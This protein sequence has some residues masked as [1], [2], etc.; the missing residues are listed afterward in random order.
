MGDFF[1]V[2]D[3]PVRLRPGVTPKPPPPPPPVA[4]GV[5]RDCNAEKNDLKAGSE[6]PKTICTK[7]YDRRR[8]AAKLVAKAAS[9]AAASSGIAPA[10]VPAPV[11]APA[12]APAPAP[13]PVPAPVPTPAPSAAPVALEASRCR[14]KG[15]GLSGGVEGDESMFAIITA[16]APFT[17]STSKQR[18]HSASSGASKS[19]GF[20]VEVTSE[21][22]RDQGTVKDYG[23]GTYEVHYTVPPRGT[24]TISVKYEDV[25]IED[26]P[27][28][29]H[30]IG[31]ARLSLF[32][33][34]PTQPF[35]S[36]GVLRVRSTPAVV[37]VQLLSLLPSLP[38]NLFAFFCLLFFF[39]GPLALS[40]AD[41][42]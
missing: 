3:V 2:N 20:V 4:Y 9:V 34:A 35:V 40:R 11:P 17:T 10:P 39:E 33:H 1:V 30:S 26:S 16:T 25:D 27:F 6:G 14:A 13:V 19:S 12:P 18:Y 5:C 32:P 41:N 31:C 22:G 28:T 36:F 29:A 21:V 42:E 24:F 23:D 8:A 7:C 38:R 37:S 15:Q